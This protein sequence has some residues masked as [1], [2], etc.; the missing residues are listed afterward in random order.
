MQ[1]MGKGCKYRSSF[2]PSHPSPG[3]LPAVRLREG[4][5]GVPLGSAAQGVGDPLLYKVLMC[6]EQE[7]NIV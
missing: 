4:G 1:V 2:A 3:S 5:G 6:K 7:S